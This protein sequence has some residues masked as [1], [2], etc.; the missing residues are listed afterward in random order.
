MATPAGD[1]ESR[2]Q[3]PPPL[4]GIKVLDLSRIMAGP[5][6]SQ[7]LADLGADVWKIEAPDGGDDTRTW[8]A[9]ALDGESTYFMSA[10]RS[11][12]SAAVNLK[13]PEGRAIVRR[14]AQMADVFI[15]N[16]RLGA[17][18]RFGLDYPALSE[19]NP[20]LIYCSIS[21]YGRSGPR[22]LEAGY[23]F[24]I[25]AESGLMAITGEPDGEP[26]KLGVAI[27]DVGTGMYAAQA[28]LAAL[29]ARSR[30]GKG[31]WIDLALHDCAVSLLA[32]VAQGCLATGEAPGRFG[33]AHASV[34]PYQTFRAADAVF[35]LAIGNDRQFRTLCE[36]V[37]D[38]PEMANDAR[39]ATNTG[40]IAHR[41][42]LASML[43]EVFAG[44]ASR[45]WLALLR[46]N[47]IP[48]GAVREVLE[49]LQSPEVEERAMSTTVSDARH[50]QLRIMA[51]PLKLRGTP[52]R[53]PTPPPRLGEH[54]EAL[55]REVLG[56]EPAQI[57]QWRAAG[58]IA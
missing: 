37:I 18:E 28:I 1:A 5:W 52:P 47:G 35:V 38:R 54:T 53:A 24:A 16:Y 19:I 55:L 44:R 26:M 17:M 2:N 13:T 21:G 36:N 56:V 43:D 6:C 27:A 33:N 20:G 34:V 14:M 30:D 42:V 9:P 46:Q 57:A 48:A 4:D 11:K 45:E 25:Q 31:Q 22:R 41:G 39:F 50:G 3:G 58:A 10:N 32:N 15:E 51:S 7:T 23:D 12:R 8:L 29:F 49:V 40:R